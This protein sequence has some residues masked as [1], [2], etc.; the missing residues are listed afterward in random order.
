M[1]T[2]ADLDFS[3]V[4]GKGF[5]Q[6]LSSSAELLC[7]SLSTPAASTVGSLTA[8]IS[9]ELD[10]VTESA[11]HIFNKNM[12]FNFYLFQAGCHFTHYCLND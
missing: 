5:A 7:G 10:S 11:K 6:T 9:A 8:E 3:L 2:K 4:T 1:K 12:P